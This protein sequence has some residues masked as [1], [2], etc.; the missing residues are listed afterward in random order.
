MCESCCSYFP[1]IMSSLCY[2]KKKSYQ[3]SVRH[4]IHTYIWNLSHSKC[5]LKKGHPELVM[6][7]FYRDSQYN[8]YSPMRLM[9]EST[10]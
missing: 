7:L 2:T 10:W 8:P 5:I 4:M 1:D 6:M 3:R 9:M